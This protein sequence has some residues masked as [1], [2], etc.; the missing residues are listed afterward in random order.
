MKK[1]SFLFVLIFTFSI[2]NFNPESSKAP[3]IK[4]SCELQQSIKQCLSQQNENANPNI[5]LAKSGCCS[6]HGGVCGCDNGRA[7]CCDGQLSPSCGC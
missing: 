5:E 3:I 1:I 6:W 4:N 7:V 2:T